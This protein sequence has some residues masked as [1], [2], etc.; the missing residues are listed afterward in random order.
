MPEQRLRMASL[1]VRTLQLM[2]LTVDLEP[3]SEMLA[4]TDAALAVIRVECVKGSVL[5]NVAASH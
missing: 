1:I 5:Q 3:I 4:V 2:Q